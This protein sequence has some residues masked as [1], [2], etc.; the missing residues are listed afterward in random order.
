ML[1][2]HQTPHAERTG[3][4][5]DAHQ[6]NTSSESGDIDHLALQA[7]RTGVARMVPHH[8]P[9]QVQHINDH[10]LATGKPLEGARDFAIPN[11]ALNWIEHTAGSWRLLAWADES[12]LT[13]ALD[14][15]PGS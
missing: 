3:T 15:L 11:A 1:V 8:L 9:V 13:D 4:V 5:R 14:E 12:H 7:R 6:V 10:R 2:L